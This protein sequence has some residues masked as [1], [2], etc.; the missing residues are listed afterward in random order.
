M[1][2]AD[3]RCEPFLIVP[4]DVTADTLG[5]FAKGGGL[6]A[7]ACILLC[8][9][10]AGRIER[11]RAAKLVELAHRAGIPLVLQDDIGAAKDLGTDGVHVEA[12]ENVYSEARRFL[13]EEA[14]V[15][16]ECGLSRHT[17]MTLG[18]QGADYV[19][20]SGTDLDA[21]QEIVSWWSEVTIVPCVAWELESIDAAQGMAHAGA[22]FVALGTAVWI[23]AEGPVAAMLQL[24]EAIGASKA[25]A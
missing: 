11:T 17:A 15:G 5:E 18:E 19:A 9:D 16:A 8:A 10:D 6:A 20:F 4:H 23:H 2:Q 13:G 7:A 25:A 3:N 1:K 14:I 22:D 24:A 12:D 21:L